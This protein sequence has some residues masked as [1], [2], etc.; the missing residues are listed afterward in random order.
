MLKNMIRID[1][2]PT[3]VVG[4]IGVDTQDN[5]A[6]LDQIQGSDSPGAID[7]R[8]NVLIGRIEGFDVEDVSLDLDEVEGADAVEGVGAFAG[9][10]EVVG[11]V[12][13]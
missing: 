12:F 11:R 3:A 13:P 6:Q 5:L 2:A 8:R 1:K 9:D 7:V 4:K 10:D